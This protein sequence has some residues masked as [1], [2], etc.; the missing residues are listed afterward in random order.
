M[1]DRFL[2]NTVW[3]G[4]VLLIAAGCGGV[5]VS[6]PHQFPVPL[7]ERLPLAIGLHLDEALRQFAQTEKNEAGREWR[8]EL[9]GAQTPMFQNLLNGM[10][11]QMTLVDSAAPVPG[12]A[13]ILVPSIQELQFSTPEQTRTDY[14][15]VWIRYQFQL[16]DQDGTLVAEWPLTAYGQSNARNFG[17]MQGQEPALQAAALAACR[18]AMAFFIVQ[19]GSIPAVQTWVA[20]RTGGST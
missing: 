19:F 7:V 11:E 12:L 2:R 16:F 18:D 10:F 4:L 5:R 20:A 9:G 8:I 17:G 3:L 15:E 13:G 14:F 1:K 6:V